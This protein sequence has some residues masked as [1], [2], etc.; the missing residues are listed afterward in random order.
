MLTVKYVFYT[1]VYITNSENCFEQ[2]F[3]DILSILY[4]LGNCKD[5]FKIRYFF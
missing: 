3:F 5:L 2:S 4:F 1:S